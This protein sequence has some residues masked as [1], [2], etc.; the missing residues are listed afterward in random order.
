MFMTNSCLTLEGERFKMGG[1]CS[2]K[3]CSQKIPSYM[4]LIS[5]CMLLSYLWVITL[6]LCSV[7]FW[8]TVSKISTH[9][10]FSLC[11]S[12]FYGEWRKKM[13]GEVD[14]F[15]YSLHQR[16]G[17][18]MG[19]VTTFF[20]FFKSVPQVHSIG[21]IVTQCCHCFPCGSFL[22]CIFIYSSVTI[23]QPKH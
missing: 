9:F 1:T 18:Y 23:I 21:L 15:A 10:I 22:F 8:I 20:F 16:H 7:I 4:E 14:L 11:R 5:P 19:E 12:R 6:F 2:Q 3:T 17:K 13:I